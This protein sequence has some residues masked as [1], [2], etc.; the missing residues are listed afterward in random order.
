[1]EDAYKY[2]WTDKKNKAQVVQQLQ[3]VQAMSECSFVPC[4][5]ASPARKSAE[6]DVFESLHSDALK[7]QQ[8]VHSH[9]T[10]AYLPL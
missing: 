1:M 10:T 3:E 8:Q 4:V 6:S 7:R 2:Y 5:S 9:A